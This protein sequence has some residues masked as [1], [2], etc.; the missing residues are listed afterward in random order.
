M[1]T[2]MMNA[3]TSPG[4]RGPWAAGATGAVVL[5]VL[6][7]ALGAGCKPDIGNPPSLVTGPEMLAIRQTPPE[8]MPGGMVTFEALVGDPGGTLPSAIGWTLCLTPKPPSEINSVSQACV[9][10]PDSDAPVTDQAMLAMPSNACALFGPDPPPVTPPVRPRDPDATGGY[11]VPVRADTQAAD[12]ADLLAFAFERIQCNLAAAP[13]DVA[14]LYNMMYVPNASPLIADVVL[15]PDGAAPAT[16]LGANGAPA[17]G[18]TVPSGA[19]A[20][21]RLSWAPESAETYVRYDPLTRM[22]IAPREALRVSWFTTAGKYGHDRTGRTGA[23][24]DLSTDNTWTAP[25]VAAPT[26]VHFW[27]V[28]RDERGGVDFT[29]FDLTVV[30]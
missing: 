23:E 19:A 12:G 2:M 16:V 10:M 4:P 27:V 18:L 29:S 13:S 28:L 15:D 5:A 1:R 6:G 3:T 26:A 30:P 8:V 22:L 21:L 9:V 20:T 17:E 7:A 25:V 24:P 14:R 11:Y